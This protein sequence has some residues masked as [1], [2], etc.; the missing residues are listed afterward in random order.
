[1]WGVIA[2]RGPEEEEWIWSSN[3]GVGDGY[4]V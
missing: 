4:V 3:E 2:L 1:M